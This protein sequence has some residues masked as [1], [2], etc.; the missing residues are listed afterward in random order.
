MQAGGN[1]SDCQL[2][3]L[4]SGAE[5]QAAELEAVGAGFLGS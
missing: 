3:T 4:L 5:D 1:R 2:P